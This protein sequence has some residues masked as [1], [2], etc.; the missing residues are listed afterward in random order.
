VAHCGN[1]DCTA[2]NSIVAVDTVGD[3]GRDTS[4]ALDAA[5]NPVISYFDITDGDLKVAHCGNPTCTAGNSIVSVDTAGLVGSETSLALDAAG[6]PVIS[7]Y[8]T[9]NSDLKVAHCGNADC[10]AGNSIVTVDTDG[11]VGLDTSLALDGSGNPVI[12]YRDVTHVDLKVAHCG[13]ANCT[14][15]NSVVAV[16]TA[17]D[18][19]WYTSL[20]LDGSGNPVISYFDITNGDLKVAHCG[21][22]TCIKPPT[23]TLGDVNC[24]GTVNAVDA[25]F[26][27]RWDAQLPPFAECIEVADVNCS[28]ATDAIDALLILR[29]VAGLPVL[30]P[31][32]CLPIGSAPP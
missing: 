11:N 28:T 24:D 20:A 30:L 27:L 12:S 19:G 6:N 32:G 29:H 22:A 14:A 16:D 17:G 9:T 13:N 2:G 15:G 23:G 7:Y 1:A 10:T 8:D 5:G 21:Y 26:V 3:V 31:K 18:V 4:L 25:L